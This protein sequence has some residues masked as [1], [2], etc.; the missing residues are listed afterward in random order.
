MGCSKYKGVCVADTSP[1]IACTHAS[2]S[3]LAGRSSSLPNVL[4]TALCF[5]EDPSMGSFE[6][7]ATCSATPMVLGT[8]PLHTGKSYHHLDQLR[9][10]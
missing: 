7:K 1:R 5:G 10:M 9:A 4:R 6:T 2:L 3:L 8:L